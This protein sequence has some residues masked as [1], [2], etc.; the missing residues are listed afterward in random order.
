MV[1]LTLFKRRAFSAGI[2][3]GLL[4]YLVTF[5]TL[6]VM[7]YL[8]ERG[9]GLSTGT[10]GLE[11]M[12]MPL[13]L[14]VTAPIAGRIGET[15]GVRVLTSGGMVIVA[16]ALVTLGLTGPSIA[17]VGVGLAF[18]GVGLGCFT[19]A[20]NASVLATVP[21]DQ[22][23]EASGVMNVTRATG[24]SLGLALTGLVYVIGSG[25]RARRRRRHRRLPRRAFVLGRSFAHGGGVLPFPAGRR[26]G[27]WRDRA[28]SN[29]SAP[30]G[31]TSTCQRSAGPRA[32]PSL[33]GE[34]CENRCRWLGGRHQTLR[35]RY[36]WRT[37]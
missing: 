7:P 34:T 16:A 26:N 25:D 27:R 24:T 18:V 22:S 20:N 37:S 11:L 32:G 6:L 5:G 17:A 31:S 36:F 8:L 9:L 14:G 23:G 29:K 30:G 1:D 33:P 15:V 28:P 35:T 13:L 3:S 2:S 21:R 12:V 4:G 19:P 10:A